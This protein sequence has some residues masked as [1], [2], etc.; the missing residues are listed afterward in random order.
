MTETFSTQNRIGDPI[1][2]YEMAHAGKEFRDH[3]QATEEA[4]EMLILR[5]DETTQ[6]IL[7]DF[8]NS[9]VDPTVKEIA[10]SLLFKRLV[11]GLDWMDEYAEDSKDA[12]IHAAEIAEE[13]AALEYDWKYKKISDFYDGLLDSPY[14]ESIISQSA[15]E[16]VPGLTEED[17]I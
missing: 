16:P 3:A 4:Q 13:T 17:T 7:E 10:C 6:S 12:H 9:D 15:E 11:G 5:S 8:K 2:A 1:K 14:G